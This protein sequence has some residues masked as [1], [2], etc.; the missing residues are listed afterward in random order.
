MSTAASAPISSHDLLRLRSAFEGASFWL[1]LLGVAVILL[2][3]AG[4]HG[5]QGAAESALASSLVL[6]DRA[7]LGPEGAAAVTEVCLT[8]LPS[9][10]ELTIEAKRSVHSDS[11][12]DDASGARLAI[13]SALPSPDRHGCRRKVSLELRYGTCGLFF[14]RATNTSESAE[15]DLLIACASLSCTPTA[16]DLSR[17]SEPAK[18]TR[19]SVPL[20]SWVRLLVVLEPQIRKVKT[21]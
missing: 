21:V 15:S 3:V 13:T 2:A 6:D 4:R 14:D 9:S 1:L 18:S 5:V 16:L 10:H 20:I 7:A 17:R 8:A 19:C 11:W 12:A